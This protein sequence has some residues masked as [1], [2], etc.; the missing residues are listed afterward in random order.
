MPALQAENEIVAAD[1]HLPVLAQPQSGMSTF[2]RGIPL[3]G[4]LL[5]ALQPLQ[6]GL[7]A[8][9]RLQLR[10]APDLCSQNPAVLCYEGLVLDAASSPLSSTKSG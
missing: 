4:T 5:P 8:A 7:M 10:T 9:Y 6:F 1:A 2:L 3:L